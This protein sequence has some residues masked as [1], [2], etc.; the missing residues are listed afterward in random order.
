MQF[1]IKKNIIFFRCIFFFNFWSSKTLILDPD[2]LIMLNPDPQH[3]VKSVLLATVIFR[4]SFYTV[5]E[6]GSCLVFDFSP[7]NILV[8]IRIYGSMPVTSVADPDPG[9]GAFLTPGSGIGF[10][11]IP[12]PKPIFLR[13]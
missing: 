4:H 7:L 3:C 1:L 8:W 5:N 13:A 10:F 11:R 12:D 6:I 9:F 2:S